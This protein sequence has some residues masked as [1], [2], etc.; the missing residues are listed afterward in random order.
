MC[1]GNE[2]ELPTLQFALKL[3][4]V[5]APLFNQFERE[6]HN[7]AEA[8]RWRTRHFEGVRD[9]VDDVIRADTALGEFA[10]D[11]SHRAEAMRLALGTMRTLY[12]ALTIDQ[13]AQ[14]DQGIVQSLRAPPSDL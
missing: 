10:D 14:F 8:G 9:D 6:I 2:R 1:R 4:E 7:A 11:D 12:A 13:R 5:Q 3:T